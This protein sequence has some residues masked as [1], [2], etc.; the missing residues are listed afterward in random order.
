LAFVRKIAETALEAVEKQTSAGDQIP[1]NLKRRIGEWKYGAYGWTSPVNL[2]IT[3]AW[4]KALYPSQDVCMIWAKDGDG[5][6]IAGGYS[7]RTLDEKITVPIVSRFDI[8]PDFCSN[9]SGMQGS[10]ALEKARGASR[11]ERNASLSQRVLF[12]LSLFANTLNDINELDA[13]KARA[14]CQCFFEIGFHVK[15]KRDATL[16]ILMASKA[17]GHKD[18]VGFVLDA[19][20]TMRDPQFVRSVVA[21]VLVLMLKHQPQFRDATLKGIES[22]KTGAD[23]QTTGS[24]DLWIE[25]NGFPS[26]AVEVKDNTKTFDFAILSAVNARLKNNPTLKTYFMI[27]AAETALSIHVASDSQ[28]NK[29][30]DELRR[31]FGCAIVVMTLRDFLG[32]A[33]CLLPIENELLNA[34]SKCLGTTPDLKKETLSEWIRILG[35]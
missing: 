34:I 8:W 24:G 12:D 30:L 20:E 11:V 16:K 19:C 25:Q 32:I 31:G 9:N 1:A 6:A 2:L 22:K 17:G 33:A 15:R 3:A 29:Q 4:V 35:K 5:K 26:L 27:T 14:A 23:T 13:E 10:R 21:A 28:W 18:V 7:I